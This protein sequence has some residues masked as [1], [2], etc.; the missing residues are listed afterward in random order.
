MS[1]RSQAT[2]PEILR[3]KFIQYQLHNLQEK[4]FVHTDKTAYLAG[5]IIWFKLYNVDE[6]FNRPMDISKVAYVEII[7]ED[8]KAVMQ[9]KN[10]PAGW[11][12]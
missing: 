5:E 9:A 1:V 2:D 7:N 8:Q 6:S 12:G 4:I 11:R 10:W 3:G